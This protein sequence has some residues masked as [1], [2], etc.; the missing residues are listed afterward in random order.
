MA[1]KNSDMVKTVIGDTDLSM[2]PPVGEAYKI[3]GIMVSNPGT[4]YVTLSTSKTT[5]GYFR[6]GGAQG[7]HL[8]AY[9]S[10]VPFDNLL[11]QLIKL[12]AWH[13]YP[14]AEGETFLITGAKSANSTQVVLYDI[15]DA[16]D[17]HSNDI[18][19]SSA[20]EYDYI[21]YGTPSKVATS[22]TAQYDTATTP[23]EFPKFPYNV[24]V[25]GNNSVEILGLVISPLSFQDSGATGIQATQRLKL[26]KDRVIL[27]DND[28]DGIPLVATNSA[29]TAGSYDYSGISSVGSAT[30]VDPSPVVLFE[31]PLAFKGGEEMDLYLT[32][33]T[34]TG[35]GVL[36]PQD[37]ELGILTHVKVG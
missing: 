28:K 15:Y 4:N 19:G 21:A 9:D 13:E 37:V 29:P 35:S 25:G 7:S 33:T 26:V 11:S 20:A 10:K 30:D 27:Y 8:F 36:A 17:V 22:P 1:L 23:E 34:V 12:G 5:I 18:N 6:V 32:T 3:K 16:G 2:T 14:V 24:Q 31:S